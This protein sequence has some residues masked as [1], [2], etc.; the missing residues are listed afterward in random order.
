MYVWK[1]KYVHMHRHTKTLERHQ[2]MVYRLDTSI[3]KGVRNGKHPGLIP[4]THHSPTTSISIVPQG[5]TPSTCDLGYQEY[6]WYRH[7]K[8]A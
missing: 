8:Q 7:T 3:K 1:Q 5:P 6:V 4:S 2:A